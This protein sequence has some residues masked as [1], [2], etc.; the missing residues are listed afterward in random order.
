ME[1]RETKIKQQ[2]KKAKR[3]DETMIKNLL[4]EKKRLSEVLKMKNKEIQ[5]LQ[6]KN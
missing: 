1:E 3:Y 5:R 2:M 4:A 6:E